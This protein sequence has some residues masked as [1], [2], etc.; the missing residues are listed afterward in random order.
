M[1]WGIRNTF[2]LVL[3]LGTFPE[4]STPSSPARL[5]APAACR[6]LS[7]SRAA[8][9]RSG[10]RELRGEPGSSPGSSSRVPSLGWLIW[11]A[12]HSGE[13][14]L[15]TRRPRGP[16][17]GRMCEESGPSWRRKSHLPSGGGREARGHRG[18]GRRAGRRRGA[19]AGELGG[20]M[21]GPARA[22]SPFPTAAPRA[23]ALPGRATPL[24]QATPGQESNLSRSPLRV[25]AGTR[26]AARG[27]RAPARRSVPVRPPRPTT[28]GPAHH[29]SPARAAQGAKPRPLP[30]GPKDWQF[31]SAPRPRE[32]LEA[33][34]RT[35]WG[36]KGACRSGSGELGRRVHHTGAG[37]R[38]RGGGQSVFY[39]TQDA[40]APRN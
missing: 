1:L 37:L 28:A 8:G 23:A 3:F 15:G 26:A 32:L 29:R 31:L 14:V 19:R 11:R 22:P 12:G 25:R 38:R 40:P 9:P 16:G 27:G 2:Q 24:R 30:A 10:A 17:R 6:T 39:G 35:N 5:S 20:G 18:A 34:R 4:S 7:N 33:Q 36:P 21:L 13:Q